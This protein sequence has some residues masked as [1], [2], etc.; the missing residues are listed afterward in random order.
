MSSLKEL[1]EKVSSYRNRGL[2]VMVGLICGCA[3]LAQV[4]L[5]SGWPARFSSLDSI[6]VRRPLGAVRHT[7]AAAKAAK[8][9]VLSAFLVSSVKASGWRARV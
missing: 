2:R 3:A 6:S 5:M 7:C 1:G 8:R 9:L 4:R